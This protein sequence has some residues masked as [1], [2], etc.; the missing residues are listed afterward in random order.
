MMISKIVNK[1]K[2]PEGIKLLMKAHGAVAVLAESDG[3][4]R[5][6]VGVC[7]QI[8]AQK[9]AEY[10]E[11]LRIVEKLF[12]KNVLTQKPFANTGTRPERSTMRYSARKLE[13]RLSMDLL[14][15]SK[16]QQLVHEIEIFSGESFRE[17]SGLNIC[18]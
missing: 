7:R 6:Q 11:A 17:S 16:F 12:L 2:G 4:W 9:R 15:T 13:G 10:I 14:C 3:R 1:L 8:S 5:E 18:A